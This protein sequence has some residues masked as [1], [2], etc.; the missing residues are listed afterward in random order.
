MYYL[1][2]VWILAYTSHVSKGLWSFVV[3]KRCQRG[4]CH[5]D[6]VLQFIDVFMTV[7]WITWPQ[8]NQFFLVHIYI[9]ILFSTSF[10]GQVQ[11]HIGG[12]ISCSSPSE[13]PSINSE[14]SLTH[15][16]P[17]I[18]LAHMGEIFVTSLSAAFTCKVITDKLR[19]GQ[20]LGEGNNM[21]LVTN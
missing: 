7:K 2:R 13:M 14:S 15:A 20:M 11:N 6:E 8:F 3:N 17:H 16:C 12:E 10:L 5:K 21:K 9:F 19:D 4:H 1:W 18:Y